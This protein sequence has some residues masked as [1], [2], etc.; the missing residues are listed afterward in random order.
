[1]LAIFSIVPATYSHTTHTSFRHLPR[2]LPN[3]PRQRLQRKSFLPG[4]ESLS[5]LAKRLQRKARP[6]A[7]KINVLLLDSFLISSN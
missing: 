3:N 2:N 1:M 4:F 6:D 5:R 7:L